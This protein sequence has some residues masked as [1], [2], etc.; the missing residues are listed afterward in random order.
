MTLYLVRHGQ[1]ESNIAGFIQGQIDSPLTPLGHQQARAVAVR[2][3]AEPVCAVYS[4]DLERARNTAAPIAGH[5]GL[6]VKLSPL[7][8]E[9]HLGEAQGLTDDEFKRAYPSEYA[10]WRGNPIEHRPP[11]AERFEDVILRCG[12]FLAELHRNHRPSETV[13]AVGHIGSI[14]GVICSALQL[15]VHAYLSI[16]V[17]NAS[18]SNVELGE[19]P[20]LKV[21]NDTC[22]LH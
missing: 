14:S 20:T 18:L 2:L 1:C 13:I 17:A 12:R 19:Q 11:G 6:E 5:H 16:H 15:P 22:H 7:L 21:L 3:A 4:S 9:C 10:L 8:R